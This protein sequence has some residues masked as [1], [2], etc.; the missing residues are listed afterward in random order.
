MMFQDG[1]T[2]SAVSYMHMVGEMPLKNWGGMATVDLTD[3]DPL[4][5]PNINSLQEKKYGCWSCPIRCGGLMKA[6]TEYKYAEGVHRPEYET[7]ASF[8]TMCLNNH[9]ES[10]IIANDI[11]NRYSLDT[12]SAGTA[13]AFAIECYE[14]GLIT[15]KDTEGV[16]LNWGNHRAIIAMTEQMAKREGLGDILADGVRAAA[17]K[18][19]GGAE[20][21]AMHVGGQEPARPR[22]LDTLVGDVG[23][24]HIHSVRRPDEVGVARQ[25]TI[26]RAAPACVLVHKLQLLLDGHPIIRSI[27]VIVIGN[28][29][30]P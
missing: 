19:G 30:G 25:P 14:N 29:R 6:G 4:D 17:A 24:L 10:V 21:F 15:S 5:G 13:I 27:K 23:P 11:C 26:V 28:S 7:L 9:P 2:A 1:G 12:I 18:I 22:S 8:G 3:I 16:E 20:K